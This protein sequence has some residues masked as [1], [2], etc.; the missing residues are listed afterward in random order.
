MRVLLLFAVLCTITGCSDDETE[1]GGCYD[2]S[3]VDKLACGGGPCSLAVDVMPIFQLSCNLSNACHSNRV[4]NPAGEGLRLGPPKEDPT[5]KMPIVPTQEELDEVHA[6]IVNGESVRSTQV[7]VA[8]GD[9]GHSWLM[10]KLDYPDMK[11]WGQPSAPV[12]EESFTACD[13][14][15]KGCGVSMPYISLALEEERLVKIRAWIA[16]GAQNN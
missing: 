16:D 12:C 10:A 13:S 11:N 9:A 4:M 14:T 5:T 15:S 8:P 3:T 7:V 6:T 1:A 2:Y